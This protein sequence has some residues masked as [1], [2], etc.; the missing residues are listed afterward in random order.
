MPERGVYLI[1]SVEPPKKIAEV[2]CYDSFAFCI[3]LKQTGLW[4]F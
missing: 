1:K 3:N 2:F 4:E